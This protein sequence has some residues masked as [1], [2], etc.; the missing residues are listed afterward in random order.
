M[1]PQAEPEYRTAYEKDGKLICP[2][3][4]VDLT[5]YS[6]EG[7]RAHTENLF[8]HIARENFSEEA[9]ARRAILLEI[10]KKKEK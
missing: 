9:K 1:S 4:G 6:A 10:A 7:V 3:T 2:E 5:D 8:P